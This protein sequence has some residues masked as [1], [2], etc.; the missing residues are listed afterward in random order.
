LLATFFSDI[1]TI[2]ARWY[3]IIFSE[4]ER[5]ITSNIDP[6]STLLG[7]DYDAMYL[8]F[9]KE[10]GLVMMCSV[11]NRSTS[12]K[13]VVDAPCITTGCLNKIGYTWDD[14]FVDYDLSSFMEI[15]FL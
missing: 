11:F 8:P 2:R 4:D 7:I 5:N 15:S 3:P 13:V 14:F 9:M 10:C 1:K 6:L 12:E